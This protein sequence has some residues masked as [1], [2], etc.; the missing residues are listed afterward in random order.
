MKYRVKE[1]ATIKICI[2]STIRNAHIIRWARILISRGYDVVIISSEP[3]EWEIKGIDIIECLSVGRS[4]YLENIFAQFKR[5]LLM[6]QRIRETKP[7]VVHIH[8]LDYIHPLV[9]GIVNCVTGDF[10]N[11]IISVWGSDITGSTDSSQ[12]KRGV[13]AKKVLLNQAREI[14]ASTRFLAAATEKIIENTRAVHIVPFGIDCR[15]FKRRKERLPAKEINL[16]FIKHLTAKYGPDYLLKAMP[17]VL[18]QVAN[19]HLTM[20]GHGN[21]DTVLKKMARDMGIEKNVSF[22]G[23]IQNEHL[24]EVLAQMDIFVMPSLYES[25][26]V[27]AIEAQAMGIPVVASNVGGVPEALLDGETGLLVE[28]GSPE[29]LA[30]AIIKLATNPELRKKMGKAG[31]KFVLDRFDIERN[32]TLIEALYRKVLV[33]NTKS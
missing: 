30:G 5:T 10:R 27:S 8:S 17:I 28:P 21:M 13:W 16:C 11:L 23:Y 24:P 18:G 25:F 12:R 7:D 4:S 20:V 6:R 31:R 32:V 3:N 15:L 19:V 9:F 1:N 2:I 29:A 26:G 14:T 33:E 22:K